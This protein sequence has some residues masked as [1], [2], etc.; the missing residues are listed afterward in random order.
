M[1]SAASG[2]ANATVNISE[3]LSRHWPVY[4]KG[5]QP[6]ATDEQN[7]TIYRS[8][9][10]DCCK[11]YSVT[12]TPAANLPSPLYLNVTFEFG[13]EVRDNRF[14][15]SLE[16]PAAPGNHSYLAVTSA[17][18]NG[19]FFWKSWKIL[20]IKEFE[21]MYEHGGWLTAQIKG[22]GLIHCNFDISQSYDSKEYEKMGNFQLQYS[23]STSFVNV[24]V[25]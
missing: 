22:R 21:L 20:G 1:V 4:L 15:Q 8:T 3:E 23:K 17:D 14:C 7:N 6:I 12:I 24:T 5:F 25:S 19:I 13:N 2:L 11:P 9:I 16:P 10:N 18:S